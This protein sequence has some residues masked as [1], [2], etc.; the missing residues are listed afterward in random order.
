MGEALRFFW[1]ALHEAMKG[2][3]CGRKPGVGSGVFERLHRPSP[4][5]HLRAAF[6]GVAEVVVNVGE[7]YQFGTPVGIF[8]LL[9]VGGLPQNARPAWIVLGLCLAFDEKTFQTASLTWRFAP[10]VSRSL[11]S[12]FFRAILAL[13]WYLGPLRPPRGLPQTTAN[14]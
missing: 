3:G 5:I 9:V 14:S 10:C 11:T 2:C 12:P 13:I 4:D 6:D 1:K 7:L 8:E